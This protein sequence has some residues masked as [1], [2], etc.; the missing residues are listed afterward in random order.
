[1]AALV[2]TWPLARHLTGSVPLGT[3]HWPTVPLF[4]LWN[5][6]WTSDR[7]GVGFAGYLDAPIFHP[8]SG[9]TSYSEPMPLIGILVAPLWWLGSPPALIY[10]AGLLTVLVLNGVF[11]YRLARALAVSP[12]VAVLGGT[13]AVTLP[14]LAN[15]SGVLPNVAVFGIF[16]CFE[17]FVRFGRSGSTG[18][19]AW[20]AAGFAATF[21]TFQQYALFAAPFVLAAAILALAERD[22]GR[23]DRMRLGVVGAGLAVCLVALAVPGL[24]LR[25]ELGLERS[26]EVVAALSA[27]PGDFF[28]RP[29]NASLDVPRREAA[30]TA[31]LFPGFLL[32]GLALV[33]L[34][35]VWRHRRRRR[36]AVLFS[37]GAL[38]T[39][40][41]ALG[42]NVAI[43]DWHPYGT[44]RDVVPG[45]DAV[46]S[47]YRAAAL[48]QAF[49]VVLATLGLDLIRSLRVGGAAAVAVVLALGAGAENLALPAALLK[50]P[51]SPRTAWTSW[52]GDQPQSSVVVHVPFPAGTHVSDYGIEARR[53]Y[54]Q[55]DHE[56]SLVNGY[57]GHFPVTRTPAGT[58]PSYTLFQL[59]MAREFPRYRLIC[60]L[61][62]SLGA[63]LVVADLE[64]ARAHRRE[65]RSHSAFLRPA[66]ADEDVEIF[67]L[68]IPAGR[69]ETAEA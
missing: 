13:M 59:E 34:A 19:A 8:N 55:I 37:V 16:W 60:V 29:E 57:S 7:L 21:L 54:A 62:R 23:R 58:V 31:G 49:A 3:E 24:S 30:D 14:F 38:G 56:R 48:F 50:L 10:N 6:W 4:S 1:M 68:R 11:A 35:G 33:G 28:T 61:A 12:L 15:V 69:C 9:V 20:A 46:R 44:L 32:T 17:G 26:D 40:W 18:A 45:F 52:L 36:W 64:W 66:Y 5:L 47:P 42:L 67:R 22:F 25:G 51:S 63:D 65:L 39:A 27:S 53:M 43:G 2:S 41:L